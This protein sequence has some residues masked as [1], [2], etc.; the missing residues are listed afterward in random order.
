MITIAF[1]DNTGN[2]YIHTQLNQM[3]WIDL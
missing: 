1:W 2:C 3:L